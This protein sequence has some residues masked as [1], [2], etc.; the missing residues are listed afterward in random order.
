[1]IVFLFTN[2]TRFLISCSK[3]ECK[4]ARKNMAKCQFIFVK[5]IEVTE[6]VSFSRSHPNLK[7]NCKVNSKLDGNVS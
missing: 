2:I 1:M 5:C 6:N 4:I 3:N 7:F